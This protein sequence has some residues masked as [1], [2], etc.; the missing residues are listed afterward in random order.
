M[1]PPRGPAHT[2]V[3]SPEAASACPDQRDDAVK[4]REELLEAS[5]EGRRAAQVK[6]AAA[7]LAQAECEHR[8]FEAMTVDAGSQQA[9]T[10]R[11]R[12][13]RR[14]YQDARN[15]YDEADGH[16]ES[17]F[18]VGA[19]ARLAELHVA[20]AQKIAQLATPVDLVDP[21][22]RSQWQDDMRELVGSFEVEAALAASRALDVAGRLAATGEGGGGDEELT[23]WIRSS[24]DKVARF[25]AEGLSRFTACK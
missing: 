6:V 18:A 10:Q 24:C 13:V 11:L 25:D 14:Q 23:G 22:G 7:V 15:L 9:M 3:N 19:S 17:R 1:T 12:V 2:P 8:A 21:A 4:A 16:G 5:G 20:F